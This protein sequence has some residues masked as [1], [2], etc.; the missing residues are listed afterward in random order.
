M[1][2]NLEIIKIRKQIADNLL[3]D[4]DNLN[5]SSA[6]SS[7]EGGALH[8]TAVHEICKFLCRNS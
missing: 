6:Q 3:V 7:I 8:N 1:R 4:V 2:T 5:D